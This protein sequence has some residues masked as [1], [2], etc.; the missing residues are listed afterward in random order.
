MHKTGL[1]EELLE[2]SR[3]RINIKKIIIDDHYPHG[4]YGHRLYYEMDIY[5]I[6]SFKM[7]KNTCQNF[8]II[9][10]CMQIINLIWP[11]AVWSPQSAL[12][13]LSVNMH[14]LSYL[15]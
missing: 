1:N 11:F 8:P 13:S 7:F 9:Y 10:M 2:I 6:C 5:R 12:F 4:H 14:G 3:G 15:G